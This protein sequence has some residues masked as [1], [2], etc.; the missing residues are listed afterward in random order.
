M[1]QS[2]GTLH[3]V[4][5]GRTVVRG[6]LPRRTCWRVS[7]AGRGGRKRTSA[8]SRVAAGSASSSASVHGSR[9]RLGRNLKAVE[10]PATLAALARAVAADC[11]RA[12]R[13]STAGCSRE[14]GSGDYYVSRI[15]LL[16]G[17]RLAV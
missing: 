14:P 8:V 13:A 12:S 9:R 2:F 3:A 10:Q 1:E 16:Y 7:M 5:A 4:S 6:L 15:R 11:P 17:R